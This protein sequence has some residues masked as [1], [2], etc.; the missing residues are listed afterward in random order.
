[1]AGYGLPAGC[2]SRSISRPARSSLGPKTIDSPWP[3][4][5]SRVVSCGACGSQL[6][7]IRNMPY[8]VSSL[9]R[10]GC[11]PC[12]AGRVRTRTGGC[13]RGGRCPCGRTPR[14]AARRRR[15]RAPRRI[16]PRL[17]STALAAAS[18]SRGLVPDRDLAGDGAVQRE[19]LGEGHRP[20]IQYGEGP[21]SRKFRVKCSTSALG[22]VRWN[23]RCCVDPLKPPGS[24]AGVGGWVG[25]AQDCGRGL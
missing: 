5:D 23:N 18:T 22:G 7:G 21:P 10:Q 12:V 16:A 2:Q 13:R 1:M 20:T 19:R 11:P 15:R 17:A 6:S 8:A 3:S 4:R 14:R 9:G 25:Q 24:P